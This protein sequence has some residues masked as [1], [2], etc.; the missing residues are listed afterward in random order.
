[1]IF[2][3][4]SLTKSDR[5]FLNVQMAAVRVVIDHRYPTLGFPAGD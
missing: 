1:M 3:G 5:E 4:T 2:G